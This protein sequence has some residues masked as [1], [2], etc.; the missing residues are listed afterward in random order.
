M[1]LFV[2]NPFLLFIELIEISIQNGNQWL[3]EMKLNNFDVD[4]AIANDKY[5]ESSD[6]VQLVKDF[7]QPVEDFKEEVTKAENRQKELSFKL[8]DLE[9]KSQNAHDNLTAARQLNFRN[10]DPAATS[11]VSYLSKL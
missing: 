8:S 4:R 10:S 1:L 7:A 11:K 9:D 2:P 3:E 6:L 5:R